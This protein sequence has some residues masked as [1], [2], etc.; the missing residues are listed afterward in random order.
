LTTA[1][2]AAKP[3]GW[4]VIMCFRAGRPLELPYDGPAT[5]ALR[6]ETGVK[7]E[8]IPVIPMPCP[9]RLCGIRRKAGGARLALGT[10][11]APTDA[12]QDGGERLQKVDA[13]ST[14]P[15]FRSDAGRPGKECI[16]GGFRSRNVRR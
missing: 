7:L 10:T 9:G 5:R 14:P 15:F 12:S 2:D 3:S 6:V 13:L 4:Y 1:N 11:K 8:S 16:R